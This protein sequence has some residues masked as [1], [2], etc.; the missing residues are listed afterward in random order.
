M[1]IHKSHYYLYS[2]YQAK[3]TMTMQNQELQS[4]L[5]A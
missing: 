3:G 1:N 4:S 2:L 5:S